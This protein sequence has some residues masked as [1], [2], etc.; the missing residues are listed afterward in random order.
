M[1]RYK[2]GLT[3][4]TVISNLGDPASIAN[5]EILLAISNK[6]AK[7]GGKMRHLGIKG[8]YKS[9]KHRGHSTTGEKYGPF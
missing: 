6:R 8:H 4:G 9:G 1:G 7:A 5:P 3:V 2:S